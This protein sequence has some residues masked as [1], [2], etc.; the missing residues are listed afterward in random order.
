MFDKLAL[1]VLKKK[2][3]VKLTTRMHILLYR[4]T[5]GTVGGLVSGM[6]NMLLTTTGRKSGLK[7]TTPLFYLPDRGNFVVVASYGG[8]PKAP[9][10]WKNLQADPT[11]WVEIGGRTFEVRASLA[12]EELKETLWP[13]FTRHY[14]AYNDYQARTDRV[15][16]LVVLE[17]V[18]G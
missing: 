6:P 7:R 17:P 14:P 4:A 16:P 5:A 10:W 1:F 15:I 8:N 13:V 18:E 11:G 9:L 3:L 12:S 2:S